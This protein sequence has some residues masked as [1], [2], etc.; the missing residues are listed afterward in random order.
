MEN[1]E[2][3]QE[4]LCNAF[5]KEVRLV[6]KTEK[7]TIVEAPFYFP[8][9][10][11]YQIYLQEIPTGGFRITDAGHT[12]MQLSY[13]ND[14]KKFK[15]DTRGKLLEQ[16]LLE[17]DLKQ[18]NGEFY[19]DTTAEKLPLAIMLMGQ[20]ITKI[21]DLTFLNRARVE[22]TFYDDLRE[23]I[24]NIVDADKIHPDYICKE[25]EDAEDYSIDYNIQ[26]KQAPLYLFGIANRDKAKL[27]TIILERLLRYHKEKF[28]S[29]LV[30]QDWETI[31]KT[32]AKRLMNIG[33]EMISS[34]DAEDDFKRKLL[35]RVTQN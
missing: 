32:D 4:Q 1:I 2:R 34:L 31:P 21:W 26:C 3:I 24:Y 13:E 22:S 16:I 9:G 23:R 25:M 8:D 30:F 33:G 5:C 27:A 10:D 18:D 6:P 12:M 17:T 15:K 14:I 35:K 7:L 19:L 20:A 11:P 29:L 28:E